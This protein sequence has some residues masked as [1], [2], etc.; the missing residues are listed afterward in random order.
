MVASSW[1][2]RSVDD[3]DFS[4]YFPVPLLIHVFNF[5]PSN[6]SRTPSCPLFPITSCLYISS[7]LLGAAGPSSIWG[8]GHCLLFD[9][10]Y[11]SSGLSLEQIVGLS[12][13]HGSLCF[14]GCERWVR[15][16]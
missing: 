13:V 11:L 12:L 2:M 8:I 10:P 16:N 15:L 1:G 7:T 6:I 14:L 5:L 3:L 4:F 9:T